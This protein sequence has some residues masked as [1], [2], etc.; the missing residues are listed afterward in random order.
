V[1]VSLGIQP[2]V[3]ALDERVRRFPASATAVSSSRSAGRDVSVVGRIRKAPPRGGPLRRRQR[4]Y[5]WPTPDSCAS[6]DAYDLVMDRAT[7]VPTNDLV[8]HARLQRP[9]TNA[10]LSRRE[11]SPATTGPPRPLETGRLPDREH[12]GRDAWAA[13]ARRWHP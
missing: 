2:T 7:P 1:G 11:Q 9:L 12:E 3:E 4:A 6:L 8:D 5:T 10:D 13:S